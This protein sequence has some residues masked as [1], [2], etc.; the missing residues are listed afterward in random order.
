MNTATG[1][2]DEVVIEAVWGLGEGLVSGRITP[3]YL[4][5]SAAL[6]VRADHPTEQRVKFAGAEVLDAPSGLRRRAGTGVSEQPTSD[7]ERCSSPLSPTLRAKLVSAAYDIAAEYGAPQDIEWAATG[8]ALHVLQTRPV[9]V[10]DVPAGSGRWTRYWAA[11]GATLGS[12]MTALAYGHALKALAEDSSDRVAEFKTRSFFG[13]RY[14]QFRGVDLDTLRNSVHEASISTGSGSWHGRLAEWL[15]VSSQPLLARCEKHVPLPCAA[16]SAE[17]LA[18]VPD[19]SLLG[20]LSDLLEETV[21]AYSC[22]FAC[23]AICA[24]WQEEASQRLEGMA[25]LGRP[26]GFSEVNHGR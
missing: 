20:L 24:R 17:A 5:V 19:A 10:V 11:D 14:V 7:E 13:R 22:S 12:S 4:A 6:G 8:G 26:L 3:H 18:A 21:A 9:T 1:V 23:G 16:G 25:A 2:D 15:A